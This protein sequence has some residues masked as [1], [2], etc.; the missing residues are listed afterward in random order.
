MVFDVKVRVVSIYLQKIFMVFSIHKFRGL[1]TLESMGIVP[2]GVVPHAGPG[3]LKE[4]QVRTIDKTHFK[5]LILKAGS[6][7]TWYNI[8]KIQ[9][10]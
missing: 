1:F 3:L 5:K 6:I 7:C 8:H 4:L 9:R 2:A 10:P